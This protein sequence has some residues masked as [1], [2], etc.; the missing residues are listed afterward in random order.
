M[1]DEPSPDEYDLVLAALPAP[2]AAGLAWSWFAAIGPALA[3]G[4]GSLLAVAPLFYALFLSP[5]A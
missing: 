1:P 4:A 2:L 3:L 5:P